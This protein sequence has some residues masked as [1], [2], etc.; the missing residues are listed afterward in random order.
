MTL[1]TY[2]Y[3]PVATEWRTKIVV[4]EQESGL[5]KESVLE[6]PEKYRDMS[7]EDA[8]LFTYRGELHASLVVAV[9]PGNPKAVI[10]C[11]QIYGKLV[12]THNGWRLEDVRMPKYGN[13]GFQG[14]EKNWLFFEHGRKL[15]FIYQ[16]QPE[17]IVVPLADNGDVEPT[18]RT[19]SPE[20]AWGI[21]RGGTA[22][23]E[24]QGKWLRFFHSLL[25][26]G[27]RQSWIYSIGALAMDNQPPFQILQV[28]KAPILRGREFYTYGCRHWKPNVIIPYGA[29][30]D[31]NSWNLYVGVNDSQCATVRITERELRL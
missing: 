29:L 8:R 2:R 9:F 23:M 3:H 27:N 17:Q 13:N 4:V 11:A 21:M 28:S 1:S 18:Y 6:L 15:H 26:S 10:P 5:K 22:P 25:Q 30:P 7:H 24:Y 16:L 20:W 19:K 14:Q 12:R 31:G